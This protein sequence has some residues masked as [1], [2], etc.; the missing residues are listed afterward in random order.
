MWHHPLGGGGVGEWGVSGVVS[1][2]SQSHNQT[3]KLLLLLW[4]KRANHLCYNERWLPSSTSPVISH[5]TSLTPT[6]EVGLDPA[7]GRSDSCLWLC[8]WM[9]T[10]ISTA[11]AGG[12]LKVVLASSD[13]RLMRDWLNVR[14]ALS[15]VASLRLWPQW[16]DK[17][18]VTEDSQRIQFFHRTN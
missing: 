18:H 11:G 14:V 9:R 4:G 7:Q 15:T 17:R 8:V 6:T 3:S 12:G 16:V 13:H 5:I 2:S 1:S 10:N